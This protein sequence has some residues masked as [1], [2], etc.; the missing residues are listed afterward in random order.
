MDKHD[1][2]KVK[3]GDT[4]L[5]H[6]SFDAKDLC[7]VDKTTA[8]Q[9]VIGDMRFNRNTGEMRGGNR[10]LISWIEI[11]DTE[12]LKELIKRECVRAL[13]SLSEE[14]LNSLPQKTLLDAAR[15]VASP[16]DIKRIKE[17]KKLIANVGTCG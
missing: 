6:Y 1:L 11:P 13:S 14:Y 16:I 10:F 5:R 2:S 9:I 7:V 12:D 4:V 17:L 15:L 8:A 3:A